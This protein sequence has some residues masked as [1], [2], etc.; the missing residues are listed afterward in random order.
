MR[1]VCVLR[2]G[3]IQPS[4]DHAASATAKIYS[5]LEYATRFIKANGT[6]TQVA[7]EFEHFLRRSD[8]LQRPSLIVRCRFNG[9][10]LDVSIVVDK[11]VSR[12]RLSKSLEPFLRQLTHLMQNQFDVYILVSDTLYVSNV[13]KEEFS[14]FLKHVPFLRGDWLEDDP[15]SCNSIAIPDP[16]LLA[17]S[18]GTEL[19]GIIQRAS[20][21]PFS[22]RTEVVKWRGRLTGPAYPDIDNYRTFNRYN[23][24]NYAAIHS[25]VIDARLTHYDNLPKTASG[26][27]LRNH[28]TK[29]FGS[30]QPSLPPEAFVQY[31]YLLS[32]D[33]VASTWKRVATILWTG[34][35]LLMQHRWK[36][37]FY[38]GLSPWVD[39]VPI[40]NDFSDLREKFDWLQGNSDQAAAIGKAGLAFAESALTTDA[41]QSYFLNVLDK[42]ASTFRS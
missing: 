13:A 37:F 39:H 42:C 5:H 19:G 36:Q 10:N 1:E 9:A 28:L 34:S 26:D 6:S 12:D 32:A 40:C 21:I 22:Q 27:A 8:T 14:T 2:S 18:Y 7:D 24:L 30:L 15:V 4:T 38:P 25:D 31:K 33:G 11:E 35:V 23:L 29:R 16:L 20:K 3:L 41:I 17:A